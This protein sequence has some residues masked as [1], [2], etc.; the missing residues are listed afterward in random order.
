MVQQEGRDERTTLRERHN[1]VEGPI[2]RQ[3]RR[4]PGAGRAQVA[5]GRGGAAGIEGIVGRGVEEVDSGG[6]GRGVGAVDE[7][8]GVGGGGKF[9]AEGGCAGREGGVRAG[10]G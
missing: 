10:D 3:Q 7:G 1:A 5:G 8:E 9:G 2:A 6:G 4:E